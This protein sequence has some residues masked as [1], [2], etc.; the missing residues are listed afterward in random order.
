MKSLTLIDN[1]NQILIVMK[2]LL[3]IY[4]WIILLLFWIIF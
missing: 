4:Y 1:Y 2:R 3:S